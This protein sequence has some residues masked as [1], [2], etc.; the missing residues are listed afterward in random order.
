MPNDMDL[1]RN[2]TWYLFNKHFKHHFL[3]GLT[4]KAV[5]KNNFLLLI[6]SWTLNTV[7]DPP[8]WL[9]RIIYF[10]LHIIKNQNIGANY[11]Y[12]L[13]SSII[14]VLKHFECIALLIIVVGKK[15]IVFR[16]YFKKEENWDSVICTWS[17]REQWFLMTSHWK[18]YWLSIE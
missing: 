9:E 15:V 12:L 3:S 17:L 10:L 7:W 13:L 16:F 1:L 2:I 18:I 5:F 14:I 11:D 6:R 4:L 8:C